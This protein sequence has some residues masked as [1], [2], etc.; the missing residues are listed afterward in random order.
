MTNCKSNDHI[1]RL[2]YLGNLDTINLRQYLLFSKE[3]IFYIKYFYK[4]Q[5]KRKV[6]M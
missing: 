3:G 4:K 6:N 5:T 1:P 2:I